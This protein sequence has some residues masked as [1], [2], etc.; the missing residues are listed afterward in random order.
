MR[1]LDIPQE[2]MPGKLGGIPLFEGLSNKA[3]ADFAGAGRIVVYEAGE[4]VVYMN[5]VA[6]ELC[7]VVSGELDALARAPSGE[8]IF[9]ATLSGGAFAG[10]ECCLFGK[11]AIATLR[12][13]EEAA[14]FALPKGFLLPYINENPKTGL[15]VLS[16]VAMGLL[17]KL[18]LSN[19]ALATEKMCF[20]SS[21][22]LESLH[23]LLPFTMQD[24]MPGADGDGGGIL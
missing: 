21:E 11:P 7:V 16:C 4:D 2:E 18:Q 24:I 22:E 8:E 23:K 1:K 14:L 10:E 20:M 13:R 15:I 17:K 5:S 9:L 19:D 12:A 6:Q 3:L